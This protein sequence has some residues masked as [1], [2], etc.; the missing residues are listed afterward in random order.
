MTKIPVGQLG[1]A[2]KSTDYFIIKHLGI[3]GTF[4]TIMSVD[5]IAINSRD[6]QEKYLVLEYIISYIRILAAAITVPIVITGMMVA[7][8][9][10]LISDTPPVT[11]AAMYATTTMA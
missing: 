2:C 10:Q 11:A 3:L 5:V 1:I 6:F 7:F 9:D 4:I 8:K